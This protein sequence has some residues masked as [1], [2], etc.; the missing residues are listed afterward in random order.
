MGVMEL[1]AVSQTFRSWNS[2]QGK[3]WPTTNRIQKK[4]K[5]VQPSF[6]HIFLEDKLLVILKTK[7]RTW[8]WLWNLS[9][10]RWRSSDEQECKGCGFLALHRSWQSCWNSLLL[11]CILQELWGSIACSA[12]ATCMCSVTHYRSIGFS[13]SALP[14]NFEIVLD[15][16][17]AKHL[18]YQKSV[19][20]NLTEAHKGN[21]SPCEIVNS[22]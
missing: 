19:G 17:N 5:A 4:R 14:L 3:R 8:D 16:V 20:W 15:N 13:N 11:H 9:T 7:T 10:S 12:L 22:S 2:T 18:V 1:T 6:F 21:S